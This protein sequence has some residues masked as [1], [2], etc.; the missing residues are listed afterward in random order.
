MSD[1]LPKVYFWG[2][3]DGLSALAKLTVIGQRMGF[4]PGRQVADNLYEA[5]VPL[6]VMRLYA[7]LYDSCVSLLLFAGEV[8]GEIE[9]ASGIIQ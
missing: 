3:N 8:V 7:R 6:P 1:T 9:L 2:L 4:V 5:G